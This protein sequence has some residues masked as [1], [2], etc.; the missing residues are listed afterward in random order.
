M[1]IPRIRGYSWVPTHRI[2]PRRMGTDESKGF[3]DR[4]GCVRRGVVTVVEHTTRQADNCFMRRIPICDSEI[5]RAVLVLTLLAT[6][7]PAL[8]RAAEGSP[9][10][11]SLGEY[12]S[13]AGLDVVV[14]RVVAVSDSQATIGD[15]PRVTLDVRRVLRS[16]L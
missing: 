14:A 5:P 2:A 1:V 6:Q 12:A 9:V 10:R 4:M 11:L 16:H 13:K 7:A 8:G 3:D 15:P